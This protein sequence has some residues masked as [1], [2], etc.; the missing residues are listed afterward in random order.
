[1]YKFN[2][3]YQGKKLKILDIQCT[4][5]G[6][7]VVLQ[8]RPNTISA[9]HIEKYYVTLEDVVTFAQRDGTTLCAPNFREQLR[10]EFM[11]RLKPKNTHLKENNRHTVIY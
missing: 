6:K 5:T 10:F 7:G 11:R 1:M 4:N 8:N 9:A 2:S 3:F